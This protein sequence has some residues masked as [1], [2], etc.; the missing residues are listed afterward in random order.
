MSTPTQEAISVSSTA[1]KCLEG[2]YDLQIHVGPDVI[3]RRIDD[4]DCAREFLARGLRGFV[5]KSHYAQ[6]G[7]RAQV[8]TRAAP[9]I[10]AF[11]ALT[12]NHSMGGL[13]P[14]AVEIAGRSRC[15]LV[16]MPT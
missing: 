5:P 14:V 11:G 13:N 16:W 12:L 10:L 1:W 8:V 15:K 2:A 9:G 7:E 3:P 4:I 6:T